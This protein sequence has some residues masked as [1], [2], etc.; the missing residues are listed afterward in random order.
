LEIK[1]AQ[2]CHTNVTQLPKKFIFNIHEVES[3][4]HSFNLDG[5]ITPPVTSVL[6]LPH[7]L[8]L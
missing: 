2:G 1:K 6:L 4:I 5:S 3:F 7:D 8:I